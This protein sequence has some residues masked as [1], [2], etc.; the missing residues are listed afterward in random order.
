M[1]IIS[2]EAHSDKDKD[3]HFPQINFSKLNLIV[4]ASATGKTKLLNTIFNG[5]LLAVR[6]DKM[7]TGFWDFTFEH[8]KQ[9]YRWTIETGND[10]ADEG[11]V[12]VLTENIIQK[13]PGGTDT[14]LV[15]RDLS[16][17]IFDG[18]ELPKL[19]QTQSSIFLLK[20]EEK[21]NPLY[22][23]FSCIVRRSFQGSEIEEASS[24]QSVPQSFINK[25]KKSKN[26]DDV[27]TSGLNLNARIYVLSEFFKPFYNSICSEFKST[28]PFI[29]EVALLKA[30]DFG[31]NLP[32][33]VP[34]F[35]MKEKYVRNKWIPLNAFSS[36]MLKVLLILTDVFTLPKDG[37][38]YLIDEYENSLGMNAIDFFPGVLLDTEFDNQF[39]ITSHHPY[40]I[41][42]VPVKNWIILHRKGINVKIKQGVE[43]EE[44]F[45]KSKQQAFVQLINDSFYTDGVE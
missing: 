35:S 17:F 22:S 34:V 19:A 27:F 36:G 8:K 5:A 45:G 11:K 24:F 40:I 28:F 26:I 2:Y 43:I 7:F 38:L 32:G 1:K 6:A 20:D 21:I 30:E 44:K 13:N 10:N 18:K 39:I 37:G 29:L 14:I 15:K 23:G 12:K 9:I 42:N 31:I 41:G 3:L 33:I 25:I 16:S 4:G